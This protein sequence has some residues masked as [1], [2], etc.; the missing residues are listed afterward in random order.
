M[1]NDKKNRDSNSKQSCEVGNR[2]TDTWDPITNRRIAQLDP[3]LQGPASIFINTVEALHGIQLRVT[4]GLRTF[5]EQ[6]LLYAKGRTAPGKIVTNARGGQS[7]HNYGL[8]F[9]VVV[10]RDRQ[11][12]WEPLPPKIAQI[13]INLGFEWGGNWRSFKDYPH[14][15]N[16]FGQSIKELQMQQTSTSK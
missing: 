6:D 9:D 12:I 11:P 4:E 1:Q 5:K 14:F 2:A 13:A 15:Q 16:T 10:M 3:R 8:A 7:Y